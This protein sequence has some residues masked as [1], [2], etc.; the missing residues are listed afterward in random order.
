MK[1]DNNSI[2]YD[3]DYDDDYKLLEESKYFD[4][5][6][7]KNVNPD[8]PDDT[9]PVEYYLKNGSKEDFP[10]SQY[11][12]S[13][14][15]RNENTLLSDTNITPLIHFL[16]FGKYENRLYRYAKLSDDYFSR[17]PNR[18]QIKEYYETIY[19]SPLFDID[20][21]LENNDVDLEGLDP[22]IHYILKGAQ[23]GF[24]PSRDFSTYDYVDSNNLDRVTKNPLYHYIRYGYSENLNTLQSEM[25]YRAN[26]D[27]FYSRGVLEDMFVHLKQKVSVVIPIYNAYEETCECIKSVLLNTTLNYELILINDCSTDERI[28][29]LLSTLEGIPFIKIIQNKTNQGFVK[30]VNLG[31]E[32]AE[33]DVVLLNSDTIVTPKWLSRLIISAYSNSKIATVTPFSNSSDISIK[34]LGLS[35]DNLFL[36]KNAY[37]VKKYFNERYL[38]SPTG[39]GF[40]LY[41]KRGAINKLG[42]FDEI[43]GMGYG[44]ETDFTSRA[45][46]AGWKNIRNNGLFIY[47]RRH[48]SF[49]SEKSDE[50]KKK[51]K[52]IIQERYPDVYKAWDDFVQSNG[53]LRSINII[54]DH[55]I[56]YKNAEQILYVCD[57][58][59]DLPNVEDNFYKIAS[60]YDTYVLTIMPEELCLYIYDGINEF[61]KLKT[62][63]VNLEEDYKDIFERFYFNM[64]ITLKIDL[65]YIRHFYNFYSPKMPMISSFVKFTEYLEIP[66]LNEGTF[67][68]DDDIV[69]VAE[70]KL[71][72]IYPLEEV[73]EDKKKYLDLTNKKVVVYTAVSG[74]YDD[75]HTPSVIE[76]D[77]DYICFT[78]NPDLKSNFWDIRQMEDL[79]LDEVRKARRYKILP[80]KYLQEYDYSLWIDGNFDI[81]GSLKDYI[82]KYLKN[83]K[84]LAIRHEDRDCVYEEA[85]ACIDFDKDDPEIINKEIELFRSENYPEH[86]GLVASGI[87]FRDHHDK[88]VIKVL[89]DWYHIVETMSYRDQLSFNYACWKNNFKYDESKIFYFK[90]PYFRRLDHSKLDIPL[91]TT[92]KAIDVILEKLNEPTSII[93]PIYDA[94]E[95]TKECIQSV[96]KYTDVPFDLILINDCS[97]DPRIRQLLDQYEEFDNIRAI[98]NETNQGFVKNVNIGFKET[99]NDVVLLNSDTIVTP[100]WL[101]KLKT[102]AYLRGNIATATP[103]SNNAGAF[104]IPEINEDNDVDERLGI[105]GTANIIE[106]LSDNTVLYV[107]TGNGFCML[108]KRGAIKKLGNFDLNFGRGYGEENDFCMRAVDDGW[109]NILD[110]STYIYHN[111]SVSFGSKEK[112]RLMEKHKLYLNTKH[113]TYKKQV[114]EFVNSNE[115]SDIRREY[116]LTLESES[117]PKFDKKNILYVIHE[118]K[119]GT[120]YT[121]VDLMKHIHKQMNVYIITAGREEI[122]LFKYTSLKLTSDS[123]DDE[124]KEQ[125]HELSSWRIKGGYSVA[126]RENKL[127]KVIYFHVLRKLHIDIV[128]IRHMIRHSLDMP[129]VANSMGIPVILSFHDFYYVCPAH[130]LIDETGTYCAG[131]CTPL[132]NE[133][134][135]KGQCNI[136][137]G[138]NAPLLK[139]FIGTWRENVSDMMEN[140]SA[141]ITTSPSAYDIYT[142]FYPELEATD[143]SIIEHGRDLETPDSVD[144]ILPEFKPGEKIRIVVPGNININKGAFFIKELMK[145]D[146]D[147][148][149]ELHFLGVVP[150]EFHLDD[151][152]V[153]H[154][155]YKRSEY[156]KLV[157]EIDP[158]FIGLFSI[159]PETYCHTL[160][161]SWTCGLPVIAIDK[162]ALGERIRENGGGYLISDD[163]KQ[164]YEDI[165]EIISDHDKYLEVAHQIP[166]IKFKTT[167]KMA[168][169]YMKIYKRY[170]E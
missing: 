42:V 123:L 156:N 148:K 87:L 51:N 12:N 76:E 115:Y 134:P 8:I 25:H 93:I 34:K 54:N 73:V 165:M 62:Q 75:L 167:E 127:F 84:C 142:E 105:N 132:V 155:P 108:V 143:F 15:Y 26:F 145:Y 166:D 124:F 19:D 85:Q 20:Y 69:E 137:M 94:Y 129:R 2:D 37:Q 97:P 90:N 146:V 27:D 13:K 96:L 160:S 3:I 168:E 102:N 104:S 46:K 71:N 16:R 81:T 112:K 139:K 114:N 33:N 64:L 68:M 70:D 30:N 151:V 5:D 120:L 23:K 1:N 111:R 86:N 43:F 164:A 136:I 53:Y 45:L 95:E 9:D 130:N 48:A 88:D 58:V 91:I 119:G 150:K 100:K 131:H 4:K 60:E 61:I 80:H 162:G 21:Y 74:N 28:N 82:H 39:N 116:G 6:Y 50:Y 170:L 47:H 59:D 126:D 144:D 77:F 110:T 99:D 154:G 103:V 92:N 141:F 153:D 106:K 72:P 98:H 31:M 159:W 14:W 121:S 78:D 101:S 117:A 89:E 157:H 135:I 152:G 56:P 118:G 17:F 128:H 67:Y 57:S 49:S 55:V 35:K 125:F 24:N 158:H 79:E 161:E 40:C 138:L 29:E 44:E 149:L 107:P 163:P 10:T 41:V 122:K 133:D 83:G 32:E 52:K 66:I 7:Y 36:N 18:A 63:P 147:D 140:V 38:E 11:F 113:P 22:I 65:M 109:T 169:E